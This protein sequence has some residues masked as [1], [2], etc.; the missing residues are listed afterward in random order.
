M[1]SGHGNRGISHSCCVV[2]DDLIAHVLQKWKIVCT[3]KDKEVVIG[4]HE[5]ADKAFLLE[6]FLEKIFVEVRLP[7]QEF[8]SLLDQWIYLFVSA[9]H[10][11]EDVYFRCWDVV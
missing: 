11:F 3:F 4:V 10:L 7:V 5:G 9:Y 8:L 1:V 2:L 6:S